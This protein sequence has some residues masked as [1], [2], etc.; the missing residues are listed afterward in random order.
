[1]NKYYALAFFVVVLYFLQ[2]FFLSNGGIGADSLSY[3]G[4]ASD[5]PALKTNLFPFLYPALLRLFY[6]A[7]VDYFWTYKMLNLFMVI[8]ILFF[9]WKKQFYFKET[10]LLFTGKTLFFTMTGAMSESL[11]IFLLYFLLFFINVF[12]KKKIPTKQ[13]VL[14]GAL[15]MVLLVA[16]R[17]SGIYIFI[18]ISLFGL[19]YWVFNKDRQQVFYYIVFLLLSGFGIVLYLFFN[20]YEFGSF[21]GEHLRGKPGEFQWLYFFRDLMGVSNV[22]NPFIGIKPS[23]QSLFSLWF[24]FGLMVVDAILLVF[25][26]FWF[27]KNKQYFNGVFHWFLWMVCLVYTLSMFVSG[28]LQQIEEMNV[29]MLVPANF[30]FFFSWLILYFQKY[31]KESRLF[32]VSVFFLVFLLGYSVKDPAWYL[33]YKKQIEPQVKPFANKI[34]L[35]NDEKNKISVSV[36]HFPLIN[37]N[38]LYPHTN[39]QIGECKQSI[40][41]TVNPQIKWLKYDTVQDKSTVLYTSQLQ[42]KR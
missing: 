24:Q 34:Y 26:I 41:G 31:K 14:F 36:Y 38:I 21:S 39:G 18:A 7:F 23:S 17:Y 4:M 13:F 1:M 8:N 20:Y 5:F 25:F 37:K 2:S 16:T 9:S 6:T 15:L 22:V 12:F 40:I 35:F 19:A 3:F 11:F 30:C 29:R 33:G 28:Y 32:S 27:K 42:L 10:V